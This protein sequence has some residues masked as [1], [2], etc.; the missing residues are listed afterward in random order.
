MNLYRELPDEKFAIQLFYDNKVNEAEIIANFGIKMLIEMYAGSGGALSTRIL[1]KPNID[2]LSAY[3]DILYWVSVE[4]NKKLPQISESYFYA[5]Q[6]KNTRLYDTFGFVNLYA[7]TL[8]KIVDLYSKS[9]KVYIS[10]CWTDTKNL[11]KLWEHLFEDI[12][13]LNGDIVAGSVDK[14]CSF[15]LTDD[16]DSADYY[17]I[18][19]GSQ[20]PLIK[21]NMD[22]LK[23]T[24]FFRSE[25]LIP[26]TI[27]FGGRTIKADPIQFLKF[28]DYSKYPN[29][30]EYW[31]KIK[32]SLLLKNIGE[33]LNDKNCDV[34]SAVVSDKYFDTGHILRIDLLKYLINENVEIDIY[35]FNNNLKFP[36]KNYKGPLPDYDKSKGLFGYKYTLI[37]ENHAINGYLTEKIA[38]GILAECLVFYWG[39]PDL[40]KIL[41]NIDGV[42]PFVRLPME[43]KVESL[44][45][46]KQALAEDWWLLR[47]NVILLA[48][49]HILKNMTIPLRI[50]EAIRGD[51]DR[52]I[53]GEDSMNL[54]RLCESKK[55]KIILYTGARYQ[56][57]SEMITRKCNST[58]I[59]FDGSVNDAIHQYGK[60]DV[61]IIQEL[62]KSGVR[63]HNSYKSHKISSY[64]VP[65]QS[66]GIINPANTRFTT[67]KFKFPNPPATFVINLMRRPDRLKKFKGVYPC[68]WTFNVSGAVDGKELVS[69]NNINSDDIKHLFRGNDFNSKPAVIGCALSHIQLWKD[70]LKGNNDHYLIYEDDVEFVGN[71]EWKLFSVM[72]SLEYN[73]DVLF[74]GHSV[75]YENT[76]EHRLEHND[77]LPVLENMVNYII[78]SRTSYVGLFSYIISR[79]GAKKLLDHIDKHGVAHGLDYLVQLAMPRMIKAYGLRPMLNFSEYSSSL[80]T[81][82]TVDTDIQ[83]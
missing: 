26:D 18:V 33:F 14:N 37:A 36:E 40:E 27:Y 12:T 72:Q 34:I 74:L 8:S 43:D 77:P 35:G 65:Q 75:C 79:S 1:T 59:K 9:Y 52:K 31:L 5:Q 4:K 80:C 73:Y 68:S 64:T 44:R 71:Y 70:L 2:K 56:A 42:T 54:L 47:R 82:L 60:K 58:L 57:L 45:I 32:P 15:E 51:I 6:L 39:C 50:S 11:Y 67:M 41:P 49:E 53:L 55:F 62:A 20:E 38:D 7:P 16:F 30:T 3:L 13:L 83:C 61:L 17:V 78:P 76:L 22:I 25:P 63:D 23:R 46:I 69:T 21:F 24:I 19:W 29:F 48:K 10:C 28:Y 66:G 81:K